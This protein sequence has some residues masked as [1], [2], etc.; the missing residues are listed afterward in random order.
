M[1][2]LDVLDFPAVNFYEASFAEHFDDADPGDQA[3]GRQLAEFLR[4]GRAA[5]RHQD[6]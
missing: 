1:L 2:W 3:R 4:L 6:A 5:G